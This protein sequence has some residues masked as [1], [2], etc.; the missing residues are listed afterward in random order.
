MPR[1]VVHIDT[2]GDL[3]YLSDGGEIELL[4]IDERCSRDRVYRHASHP[5]LNGV[6]DKLIGSSRIGELGDMP[7]TEAAIRAVMNGDDQPATRLHLV[8]SEDAT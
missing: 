1:L 3:N 4:I 8:H 6:I 7:G 2:N 5:T